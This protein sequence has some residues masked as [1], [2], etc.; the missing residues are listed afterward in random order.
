MNFRRLTV[1]QNHKTGV[2]ELQLKGETKV[3]PVLIH[4]VQLHPVTDQ[5]LHADFYQVSLKEKVTTEI[6]VELVGESPAV[7]EQAGVL[8]QPLSE[9]EV[10]ALPTELPDKFEEDIL[11]R[12]LPSV[13]GRREAVVRFGDPIPVAAGGGRGQSAA[14]TEQ[15]HSG[16]QSLIDTMNRNR[17]QSA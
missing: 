9:V 5:P 6:P 14:L 8:T 17:A 4:N 10:E 3:R 15:L 11:Q 12:D 2:V 1:H 16:V 7:K 13:R